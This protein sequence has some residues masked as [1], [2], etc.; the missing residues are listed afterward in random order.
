MNNFQK[1]NRHYFNLWHFLNPIFF[2]ESVNLFLNTWTIF[3]NLVNIFFWSLLT[4]FWN[5]WTFFQIMWTI[6]NMKRNIKIGKKLKKKHKRK[7]FMDSNMNKSKIWINIFLN[8][9]RIS[10]TSWTFFRIRL[11][12]F[13]EYMIFF[14]KTSWIF[15]RIR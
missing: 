8:P 4:I 3:E 13:F 1:M 9:W 10:W 5:P 14:L 2:F 7:L 12:I 15:F 11:R 6:F